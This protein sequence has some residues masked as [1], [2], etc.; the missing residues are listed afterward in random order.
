VK[1]LILAGGVV[2]PSPRLSMLLEGV[3]LVIAADGGLRHCKALEVTPDLLVGDLDSVREDM[4]AAWPDLPVEVHRPDKDD[5]DLELAIDAALSRG[6]THVLV[7]GAA[8]GRL[9]QT[10]AAAL[11]A[12]RYAEAGQRVD[13]LDGEHE[14]YAL[15][16]GTSRSW[17]L[18]R[19]TTFSVLALGDP[20]RVDVHGAAFPLRDA[21]L[22]RG[23]GLGV[24][25]VARSEVTVG[26]RVGLA[27]VII[28]WRVD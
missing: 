25:N 17:H 5:L 8:G 16:A 11:V 24:S 23:V 10:L 26:V 28:A 18:P 21:A 19:G 20:A 4:R 3:G 12:G 13:L 9:D 15:A 6:A 7:V 2:H 1:A 27:L 22:P 14:T